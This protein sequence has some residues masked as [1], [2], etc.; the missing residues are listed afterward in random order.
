M[1]A[2]LAGPLLVRPA[3]VIYHVDN[4]PTTG[5]VACYLRWI[6]R[7]PIV[8]H[9]G[10]LWPESVLSSGMLKSKLLLRWAGY[11]ISTVQRFVFKRNAHITVITE[12]FRQALIER[13][14]DSG[15]VSV[16]PNWADEDRLAPQAPADAR[17]RLGFG[18]ALAIV[19][20]GNVGPLQALDVLLRAGVLLSELPEVRIFVIG[21][22]P[23]LADLR[24]RA[25][26]I[27]LSNVTFC[28]RLGVDAMAAV[29]AAADALLIHLKDEPFLHATVPSK[30]QVA[31]LAGR[32]IL[33]GARGEA[34]ELVRRANAGFVFEPESAE[35]LAAAVRQFAA[36]SNAER[37]ALGRNG[38]AY[39][40]RVLGLEAGAARMCR[41]FEEVLL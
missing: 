24:S 15:R 7:A 23:S 12:G 3:D 11:A 8:Q 6:W 5:L 22:G 20:A 9:I 38:R 1:S 4:L 33:M 29:N 32:P 2:L 25:R 36:L 10:D 17:E 31:M 21:D 16:L 30:T 35:S 27:G 14:V 41:I 13:G 40:K 34:A 26:A 28:G 18:D 19:Y 39:Y 37:E